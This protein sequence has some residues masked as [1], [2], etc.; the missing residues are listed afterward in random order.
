MQRALQNLNKKWDT[1]AKYVFQGVNPWSVGLKNQPQT[2]F[3]PQDI[4]GTFEILGIQKLYQ[5][6]HNFYSKTEYEVPIACF[7][8]GTR[9]TQFSIALF[10]NPDQVN[11]Q[12][13]EKSAEVIAI[14]GG[15][16]NTADEIMGLSN[17]VA[18]AI[19]ANST[20]QSKYDGAIREGRKPIVAL[21]S[22]CL[23][24]RELLLQ[25]LQ[26]LPSKEK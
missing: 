12:E 23:I 15:M 21:K 22:G 2:Y 14:K 25:D 7:G 4:E 20:F 10:N 8:I 16:K 9:T 24:Q 3:L 1:R 13:L 17:T 6:L 26:D 18:P 5:N 11:P 19:L